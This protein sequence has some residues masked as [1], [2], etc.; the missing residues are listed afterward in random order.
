MYGVHAAT[1][2]IPMLADFWF[3]VGVANPNKM[4]LMVIYGAYFAF[5]AL[6][7]LTMACTRIPFPSDKKR[8]TV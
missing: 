5:P 2:T 3:G 4:Q 1:T 8:K 6:I 7:A